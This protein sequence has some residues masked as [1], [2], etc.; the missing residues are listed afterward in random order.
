MHT[1]AVHPI[2]EAFRA[3]LGLP[4]WL[5]R[6]GHGSF[7]TLEFGEPQLRVD[8]PRL[9][10]VFIDGGPPKAMV[11]GS[12]VF[13]QWHLWIYLCLWELKLETVELAHCESDD[14]TIARALAV[15]NGQ[16]LASVEVNPVNGS[17]AFTFD[18][19]CF[20][21][22]RPAPADDSDGEPAE[23]WMLYQPL[24]EV[25][26]L[27]SDGQYKLQAGNAPRDD[28]LWTPLPQ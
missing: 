11:R 6:K 15:L 14:V 2:S 8:E 7:I 17:T 12:H 19:G 16:A 26:T 1:V 24:G 25:L 20:L 9:L 10:P 23:Q 13:G 21:V 27:R 4:S 5:V 18:L 3:V 22:T 28:S